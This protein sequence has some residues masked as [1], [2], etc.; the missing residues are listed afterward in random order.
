M[1]NMLEKIEENKRY[2]KRKSW[3][4]RKKKKKR[5]Q[6]KKRKNNKT[7]EKEE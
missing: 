4:N 1:R 6:L 2:M 7:K 5:L 3:E